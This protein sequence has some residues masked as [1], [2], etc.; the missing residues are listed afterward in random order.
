[1]NSNMTLEQKQAVTEI[2]YCHR[3]VD[4]CMLVRFIS[5]IHLSI[6]R[7]RRVRNNCNR[8]NSP[9]LIMIAE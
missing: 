2:K 7:G 3:P 4:K 8:E 6:H 9:N 1:M 5:H